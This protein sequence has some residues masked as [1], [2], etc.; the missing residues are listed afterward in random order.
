MFLRYAADLIGLMHENS[1]VNGIREIENDLVLC[2]V[3]WLVFLCQHDLVLL[4]V[5]YVVQ[6][7]KNVLY[8]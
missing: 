5:S 4:P 3:G 7:R 8:I 6:H 1:N 2:G